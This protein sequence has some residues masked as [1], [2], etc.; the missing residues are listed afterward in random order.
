MISGHHGPGTPGSGA[1]SRSAEAARS[2]SAPVATAERL[3]QTMPNARLTVART[4]D[5]VR[6]WG[7]RAAAFLA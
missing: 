4:L 6:A 1:T 2:S 5:E 7:K 3:T